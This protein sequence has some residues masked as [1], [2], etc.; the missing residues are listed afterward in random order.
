MS[1]VISKKQPDIAIILKKK[2]LNRSE[3]L[4]FTG[5]TVIHHRQCQQ[6]DNDTKQLP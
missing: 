6:E 4:K 1:E 2:S 5:N 3:T